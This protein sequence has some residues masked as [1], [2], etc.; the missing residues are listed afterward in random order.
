MN[1]FRSFEEGRHLTAS[2]FF[3]CF[4]L[5]IYI[6]KFRQMELFEQYDKEEVAQ[7]KLVYLHVH[8]V[9]LCII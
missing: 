2:V 3:V 9:N 8:A 5:E 4:V 1:Q 6:D 7:N